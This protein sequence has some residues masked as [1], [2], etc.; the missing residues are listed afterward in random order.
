M[1]DTLFRIHNDEAVLA[2]HVSV[3]KHALDYKPPPNPESLDFAS[4]STSSGSIVLTVLTRFCSTSD[5]S[6]D[7]VLNFTCLAYYI[8]L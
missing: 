3:R 5:H 4:H 6:C 2:W 7:E 8:G 1:Q